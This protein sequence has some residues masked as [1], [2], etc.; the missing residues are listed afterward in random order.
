MQLTL[1]W[2]VSIVRLADFA[3]FSGHYY[4][5]SRQ[6]FIV[7]LEQLF[8]LQVIAKSYANTRTIEFDLEKI[9]NKNR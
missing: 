6:C 1:K 9:S 7:L 8:K 4:L 5:Q 2:Q 3:C